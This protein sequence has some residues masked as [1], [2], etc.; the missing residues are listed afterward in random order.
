MNYL[1]YTINI[2]AQ[3]FCYLLFYIK[4]DMVSIIISGITDLPLQTL[5]L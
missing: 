4:P 2:H 1:K 5:S 3:L